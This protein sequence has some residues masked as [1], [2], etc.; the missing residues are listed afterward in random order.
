MRSV[1]D[2]THQ[3][4]EQAVEQLKL[5]LASEL[6][7][8]RW[9]LPLTRFSKRLG[10]GQ[11][12]TESI[13]QARLPKVLK[14]W[15]HAVS[16]CPDPVQTLSDLLRSKRSSKTVAKILIPLIYPVSILVATFLLTSLVA[17]IG[18]SQLK[19]VE[20]YDWTRGNRII[21]VIPRSFQ[22]QL[23]R[24]IAA[25]A[26]VGWLLLVGLIIICM[27]PRLMQLSLLIH[28][29]WVGKLIQWS[30][31]R[32]LLNPLAGIARRLP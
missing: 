18:W 25:A 6:A 15:L 4:P 13:D 29:P 19:N 3:S 5:Q 28:L 2:A 26:M 1:P 24:S 16:F 17:W 27:A 7:P 23:V 12:W 32:D 10:S 30:M 11:V 22:S 31:L 14:N 8:A 21:D 20:W 9:R